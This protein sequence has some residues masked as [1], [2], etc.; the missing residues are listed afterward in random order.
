MNIPIESNNANNYNIKGIGNQTI[1]TN[2]TAVLPFFGQVLIM[3]GLSTPNLLSCSA[4]YDFFN[5]NLDK[6]NNCFVLEFKKD[7]KIRFI[8]E[9]TANGLYCCKNFTEKLKDYFEHLKN[10]SNM[11]S[12]SSVFN[13]NTKPVQ[14]FSAISDTET[15]DESSDD[16]DNN[17]TSDIIS[18]T[19]STSKLSKAKVYALHQFFAHPCFS[20][21][22][23]IIQ[24]NCFVD[25]NINMQ[26]LNNNRSMI[27]NCVACRKGKFNRSNPPYSLALKAKAP[28]ERIH[29]DVVNFPF[30]E[31]PALI[32]QQSQLKYSTNYIISV[33]EFS[34]YIVGVEIKDQ[35]VNT[36]IDALNAIITSYKTFNVS[37]H[38]F[39]SDRGSSFVAAK[40]H[41][42]NLGIEFEYCAS[43]DHDPF[44]ER[45]VR[46]IRDKIYCTLASLPK[47]FPLPISEYSLIVKWVIQALNITPK[48]DLKFSPKS[49]ISNKEKISLFNNH[50]FSFGSKVCVR[51]TYH[52][53]GTQK[54]KI[55]FIVGR[56]INSPN[57]FVYICDSKSI[58][59]RSDIV[60]IQDDHYSVTAISPSG[61][62]IAPLPVHQNNTNQIN[63]VNNTIMNDQDRNTTDI[64]QLLGYVQTKSAGK[65]YL[66]QWR[67]H[68]YDLTFEPES[69]LVNFTAEELSKIKKIDLK[70]NNEIKRKLLTAFSA[71]AMDKNDQ[72]TTSQEEPATNYFY[73][74]HVSIDISNILNEED[75]PSLSFNNDN[76]SNLSF[77]DQQ[78]YSRSAQDYF[79]VSPDHNYDRFNYVDNAFNLNIAKKLKEKPVQTVNAIKAEIKQMID[80]QA[81]EPILFKDIPKSHANK[82]LNTFLIL[83]EKTDSDGNYLTTKARLVINGARE[84]N[85][86]DKIDKFAPNVSQFSVYVILSLSCIFNL[87]LATVDIKG[88]FLN[89]NLPDH[90]QVYVRLNKDISKV[91]TDN[92]P[93]KYNNY[94]SHNTNIYVKLHKTIY[95][96]TISPKQWYLNISQTIQSLGFIQCSTDVCVFSKR[97]SI[98][99]S[100][101]HFQVTFL[102][103]FVDDILLASNCEDDIQLI[104]DAFTK[105]YKEFTFHDLD[106]ENSVDYLGLKIAKH[107]SSNS[108]S[109]SAVGHIEE[110]LKE[111]NINTSCTTPATT[112]SFR[113]EDQSDISDNNVVLN[114]NKGYNNV[115]D[116]MNLP[117]EKKDPKKNLDRKF[118]GKLMKIFYISNKYRY[119]ILQPVSFLSLRSNKTTAKD[120]SNLQRVMKYLHGTKNDQLHLKPNNLSIVAWSDAS[121]SIHSDFT[122]HTGF[123]ISISETENNKPA[124]IV[125]AKSTKQRSVS[126]SSFE[127]EIIALQLT[128]YNCIIIKNL[129]TE[130]GCV[131]DN[132]KIKIYNDNQSLIQVVNNP[133]NSTKTT[134]HILNRIHFIHKKVESQELEVVYMPSEELVSDV[135][136]KAISGKKFRKFK[137]ELMG[138]Q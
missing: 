129:L 21:M 5:I 11:L 48:F 119:D 71:F 54:G 51:D 57:Y 23:K 16:D 126:R 80:T 4:A 43:E 77:S 122:S 44:V 6:Q 105:L 69:N 45:S 92:Y 110:I 125:L 39:K 36:I 24:S 102:C 87:H 37:I 73:A 112:E 1:S 31:D 133:N 10:H 118:L 47:D 136:T 137:Q 134:R 100:S 82:I 74:N 75:N 132:P 131:L 117:P 55:G 116:D 93:M 41:V 91:L 50:M 81:W 135:L 84:F 111:N 25:L 29:L 15:N 97:S 88:A 108:I 27:D 83:K 61:D 66:I 130:M 33:D 18:D 121:Y 76:N 114:A 78:S 35:S 85:L 20:T 104:K 109:L 12:I 42:N 30:Y 53:K 103:L 128:L 127:A 62:T 46:S 124:S 32:Y 56:E 14:T 94:I 28:G 7:A 138:S 101:N 34:G 70:Y 64:Q 3:K 59:S 8:F 90:V 65:Y 86:F 79:F 67:D 107:N 52:I 89:A 95:G 72:F 2:L 106:I 9:C 17:S 68:Q 123:I 26:D 38:K 60:I 13:T 113:M 22:R 98:S 96:L 58:V 63:T 19:K 40:S 49:I 115:I 99:N 120:Y